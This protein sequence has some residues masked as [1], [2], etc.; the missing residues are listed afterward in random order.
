[1][2]VVVQSYIEY[3][4]LRRGKAAVDID[5]VQLG[6]GKASMTSWGGGYGIS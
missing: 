5:L 6:L 4:A 3:G 2:D 1:M